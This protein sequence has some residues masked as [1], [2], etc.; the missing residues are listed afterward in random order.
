[1][2]SPRRR[3]SIIV[4]GQARLRIWPLGVRQ[5]HRF[6]ERVLNGR[7]GVRHVTDLEGLGGRAT[8]RTARGFGWEGRVG[9]QAKGPAAGPREQ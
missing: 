9:R 1:M 8:G 6:R 4:E 3:Q 5:R 2:R 7:L